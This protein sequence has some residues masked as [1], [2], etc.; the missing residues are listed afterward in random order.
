MSLE[1]RFRLQRGDF[2]LDVDFTAPGRGVTAV[3]GRSGSGKTTLLRCMAGL[4]RVPAA[5]LLLDGEVW[6]QGE[7]F[8]PVH[9]RPIGMVFQEPSL[10]PHLTVRG[11]LGYGL[12]R[13][14]VAQRRLNQDEVVDL[15]DLV[16]LLQRYPDQLSGGQRQRVALGRALLASPRLLLMDEPLAALDQRSR[17]DIL[18]FLERI[19]EQ[20]AIP[21]VYVSH[22]M[23]EVARLADHMLLLEQGR[24]LASGPVAEVLTRVDLPLAHGEDACAVLDATVVGED[25]AHHLIE[26]D[27]GGVRLWSSRSQHGG[28]GRAR[29]RIA[30]RDVALARQP[31]QDSSVLNCAA[32]D[33]VE[34]APDPDPAHLLVHLRL[35]GQPLLARITR[36]S[37]EQLGLAPGQ[38]VHAL[39]KAVAVT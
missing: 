30:A 20:F 16:S 32:V 8:L 5:R 36:R 29:L 21:T 12:R 3:F 19:I 1:A 4:Q 14:P 22:S 26:L 13:V 10:F 18:P 31:P 24:L 2:C 33:I 35:A 23:A 25:A 28:A 11:N 39:I 6:Q 37:S 27:C 7:Q 38:R 15:L 34:L 9:R 17:A